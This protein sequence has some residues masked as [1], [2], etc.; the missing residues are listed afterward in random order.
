MKGAGSVD[1]AAGAVEGAGSALR[2][3]VLAG[4][5]F[6]GTASVGATRLFVWEKAVDAPARRGQTCVASSAVGSEPDQKSDAVCETTGRLATGAVGG[7]SGGVP[8]LV[9]GGLGSGGGQTGIGRSTCKNET[10]VDNKAGVRRALVGTVVEDG[11]FKADVAPVSVAQAVGQGVA[12]FG[13][14]SRR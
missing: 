4:G 13:A 3:N 11:R 1:A 12:F 6:V 10:G 9:A 7:V 5:G 8:D 2:A 14:S